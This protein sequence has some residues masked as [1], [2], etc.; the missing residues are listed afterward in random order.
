MKKKYTAPEITT[1]A[2][3]NA[4]ILNGSDVLIDGSSLFDDAQ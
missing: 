3:T 4:D 2:L 1:T